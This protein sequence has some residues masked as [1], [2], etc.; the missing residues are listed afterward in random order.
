MSLDIILVTNSS[1]LSVKKNS[2]RPCKT[3]ELERLCF[4]SKCRRNKTKPN[5]LFEKVTA[6]TLQFFKIK[7]IVN[8]D[9]IHHVLQNSQCLHICN[10]DIH[11][12]AWQ[13]HHPLSRFITANF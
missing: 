8:D 7:Y 2:C 9:L 10:V 5:N 3:P 13:Y 1:F 6:T 12:I 11:R 4:L